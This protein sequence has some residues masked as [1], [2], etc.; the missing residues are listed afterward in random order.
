MRTDLFYHTF[1]IGVLL[2]GT[3]A[4]VSLMLQEWLK[5][6]MILGRW[7]LLLVLFWI[8]WRR[9]KDRWK[10]VILKPLGLCSYCYAQWVFIGL[11]TWYLRF[12]ISHGSSV[13]LFLV[14][15]GFN[16]LIVD[17]WQKKIK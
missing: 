3:S 16:F 15:S 17:L 14:G 11:F 4:A 2:G 8:R 9:K 6:G 7:Y 1:A 5:P 12:S 10:R 13:V